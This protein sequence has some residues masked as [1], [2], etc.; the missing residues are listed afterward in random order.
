MDIQDWYKVFGDGFDIDEAYD[1]MEKFFMSKNNMVQQAPYPEALQTLVDN[2][3][4]RPGWVFNLDHIDRGQGSVG[5]TLIVT[6]LGYDTYHPERGES[7]QV[8]HYF[9]V[10]AAGFNEPSWLIWIHKC[11]VEIETHECNEFLQIGDERPFAPHHGPGWDPY[12]TF[13]HGEDIDRRT[14]FRGEV[15][16][17]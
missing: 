6:S 12:A 9:I 2:I 7:Y 14:N 5:L 16:D 13:I 11:L 3:K 15:Q 4:Y 17:S 1:E 10:P 8:N